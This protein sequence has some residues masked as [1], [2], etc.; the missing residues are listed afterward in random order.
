[1]AECTRAHGYTDHEIARVIRGRDLGSSQHVIIYI[2]GDNGT[3]PE[4]TL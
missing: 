1:M 4:G 2:D 3:S